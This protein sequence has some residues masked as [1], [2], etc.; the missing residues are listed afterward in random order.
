MLR[1]EIDLL[2]EDQILYSSDL[3]HGEGRHDA[4]KEILARQDISDFQKRKILYNNAV[5]FFGEP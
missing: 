4:A 3:P 2:G 1:E 5:R